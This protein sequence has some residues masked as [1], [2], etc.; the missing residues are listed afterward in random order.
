V[1]L[2][3]H[4]ISIKRG[5]LPMPALLLDG[6]PYFTAAEVLRVAGVSRGTLW[7]WRREGK[8][9][10]GLKYRDKQV[11]FTQGELS[12]I[13]EYAHRLATPELAATPAP[14]E[15]LRSFDTKE[16]DRR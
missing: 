2:R 1:T 6:V 10:V 5:D 9:P 3:D 14:G 13:R 11:L 15:N 16:G 12:R 8:V 7:R 4:V